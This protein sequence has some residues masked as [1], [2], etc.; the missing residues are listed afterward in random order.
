VKHHT[1]IWWLIFAIC[2]T[3]FVTI[4]ALADQIFEHV[5]HSEDEVAYVFQ[6]K[7]FAQNRLTAPTPQ[8]SDAFWT[9]FVVDYQGQRFGKYPPGWPWLLSLGIRLGAPW[10]V[11]ALLATLTLIL[12]AWLGKCFYEP[13]IGLWAAGLALVTPGF[14]FL[15]SSLLSHASSLFWATLVLVALFYSIPGRGRRSDGH[16][17]APPGY[18]LYA[19][20]A[21]LALG[22]VFITRPFAAFG[23]GLV[24]GIFLLV[25][26]LRRELKWTAL[27]WLMLGFL[28]IAALL[29][30]YWWAITGNP[31]FNPYLLVWPYDRIGFGPN[32]GA[33]GYSPHDAIF[34]NTRL[35]LITLATGLFGWP[36]WSSLLFLPIPFLT[37]R[38]NRWDW[39]LLG[40]IL[41]IIFVHIFYWAFGGV[42]GG[43]PRYYYDALPAL[44]LLTVRGI[45]ISSQSLGR[46]QFTRLSRFK[47]AQP[48]LS[49]PGKIGDLAIPSEQK[50]N[51]LSLNLF[52]TRFRLQLS[53]LPIGLV[54]S[55]IIYNLIWNL[56]PLLAAQKGKYDITPAPLQVVE[57]ANLPKPALVMVKNVETWSEFAAPF[58]ANSPTLD[59]PVVYAID[60]GPALT[61]QVREQFKERTCWELEREILRRCY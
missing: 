8:N 27:L 19:I 54:I 2:L 39:L 25:L 18:P 32:I 34:I 33:Y 44:L 6:A 45:H 17:Y 41:G 30:L 4:A 12:I 23:I 55:F 38:A 10:L 16:K 35:K 7:V 22:A 59:G 31:T 40:A 50:L 36:G 60:W 56:P 52:L 57:K 13:K 26:I 49:N 11:N 28:S 5:P 42:D 58:A 46:W 14:L 51:L 47:F 20:I 61:Q 21:G 3:A 9:P 15:S 53:W 43:F 29:P 48:G 37:R 24:V 1:I